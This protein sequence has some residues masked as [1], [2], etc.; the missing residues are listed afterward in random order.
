M[1]KILLLCSF[2]GIVT[3]S[4]AQSFSN[5]SIEDSVFGWMKVYN[6]KGAKAPV[7]VDDKLYSVAQLSIADSFAN[8][9][10]ATYL[11]KGGLGDV[12]KM[13]SEKLGL[14][15]QND[16]ALPQSY[17]AYTKTY[18]D[19]KY[20]SSGKMIPASNSHVQWSIIANAPVGISA[21]ALCT[22]SQYYFTLPSFAEQGYDDDLPKLYGLATHPNTKKYFT[23]FRR[24]SRIGNEK[25]VVLFAQN[26]M[27]FV[28]V[29]RGEY[30]Q[31]VAA[32]IEKKYA[33]EKEEAVTKW[34]ND[35]AR[36][37]ARKY[38]DDRYQKRITVLKNNQE[39]YKNRLDE[40]AEIFTTQPDMLLENYADVFEGNG[41]SAL[42]LPV[43]R[44]DPQMAELCKKDKPQWIRITWHGDVNEPV[45]KHQHE[46]IINNFNFQYVYDFFFDADKM[47]G[48]P[49]QPLRSPG[50]K[51]AVV[52]TAASEAAK[53]NNAD[54]TVFFFE[55]FSTTGIGKKPIGWKTILAFDGTTALVTK[56]GELDGNW[57]ELRGHYINATLLKKPLPQNF[58]LTYDVAVPQNFTWG[59]KGLTMLLAKETSPGNAESFISLKLRPGSNGN[60][61]EATVETKFP[62]PPGYSNGTNWYVANGLS[63]NKKMNRITVII[64]KS[65]EKLQVFINENK[66]AEYEKAIP[67]NHLFNALSFNCSGNSAKNDAYFISNIKITKL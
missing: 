32:G 22:P 23:Y 34:F 49:Y 50:Y 10:Q 59:A 24:N 29:T 64:K 35:N 17:G 7:K 27:P 42:K 20:N 28:K 3:N 13:V 62:F 33:I 52:T 45:G 43:Y 9:M 30:L 25:T 39:K 6:F 37:N 46:T 53:K 38:A 11:P 40:T 18:T 14:Y 5:E 67:L 36:A 66:I 51:E 47:K 16:A 21:D 12:K 56:P 41:G 44:I 63:N 4:L 55:D 58:T 19:L 54:A 60:D 1:I 31:Q 65:G 26:T 2:T 48:K 57:V 15:N 8:W 61:G